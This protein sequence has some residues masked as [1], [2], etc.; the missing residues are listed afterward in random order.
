[1]RKL[2][3]HAQLPRHRW[4]DKTPT[5]RIIARC[6]DDIQSSAS[7]NANSL[8]YIK[9]LRLKDVCETIVARKLDDGKVY[10]VKL[11]RKSGPEAARLAHEAQLRKEQQ[12]LRILTAVQA[13]YVTKLWWSFEDAKAMYIVMVRALLPSSLKPDA[14]WRYACRTEPMARTCAPS[15]RIVDHWRAIRLY[16]A[17]QRW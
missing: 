14:S 1:M 5:S 4:L 8:E 9:N 7:V 10:T 3:C 16:L 6:T 2:A 12:V 17:P 11:V 13:P 15:L